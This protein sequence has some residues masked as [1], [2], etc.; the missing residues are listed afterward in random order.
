MPKYNVTV[1]FHTQKLTIDTDKDF[2]KEDIEDLDMTDP[3]VFHDF[4][5]DLILDD[6]NNWI[7]EPEVSGLDVVKK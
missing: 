5:K 2:E 7:D 3:D 6:P 1:S 4:L